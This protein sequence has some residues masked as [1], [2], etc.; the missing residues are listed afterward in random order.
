MYTICK[1]LTC[2]N[3]DNET[4]VAHNNGGL[5]FSRAFVFASYCREKDFTERSSFT[6][7]SDSCAREKDGG[8]GD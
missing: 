3:L 4:Y 5:A 2:E 8:C 1:R 6:S 7:V